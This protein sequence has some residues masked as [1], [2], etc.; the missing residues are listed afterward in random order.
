MSLIRIRALGCRTDMVWHVCMGAGGA[1]AA[2]GGVSAPTAAGGKQGRPLYIFRLLFHVEHI[3]P[4]LLPR[5]EEEAPSPSAACLRARPDMESLKAGQD[6]VII[7]H[8]STVCVCLCQTGDGGR[9]AAARRHHA[10]G[11]QGTPKTPSTALPLAHPVDPH[12]PLSCATTGG[13]GGGPQPGVIA[14]AAAA[15]SPPR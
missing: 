13:R 9:D 3:N 1:G 8:I 10:H 6:R 5:V 4:F 2:A 7:R 14:V 11:M 12:A 15:V